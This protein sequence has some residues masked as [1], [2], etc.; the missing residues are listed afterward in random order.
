MQARSCAGSLLAGRISSQTKSR[1]SRFRPSAHWS[2]TE[3]LPP[4]SRYLAAKPLAR[5]TVG[6]RRTAGR[7]LGIA[8]YDA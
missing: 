5:N 7:A 2:G 4:P 6:G 3:K 8:E 1:P